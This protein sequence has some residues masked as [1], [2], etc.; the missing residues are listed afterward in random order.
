MVNLVIA[1]VVGA[2]CGA[3][4]VLLY[5]KVQKEKNSNL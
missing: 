2:I 1:V 4:A 3:G 5:D